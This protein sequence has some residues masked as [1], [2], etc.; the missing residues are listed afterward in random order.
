[1]NSRGPRGDRAPAMALLI[2]RAV[3]A[4]GR[5]ARAEGGARGRRGLPRRSWERRPRAHRG[6]HREARREGASG[7]A[8]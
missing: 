6:A 3:A 5:G 7:V 1:M 2:V 4:P 8:A